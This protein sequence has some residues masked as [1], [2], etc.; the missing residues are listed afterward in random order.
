MRNVALII[1]ALGVAGCG[2]QRD[3]I[4]PK[5]IPAYEEK[6]RKKR[7]DIEKERQ[8]LEEI[9]ARRAA[10]EAATPTPAQAQ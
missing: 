9:D 8:Q 7:E 2:V 5:D 1:L 4:R 6:Q 10:E 3:L